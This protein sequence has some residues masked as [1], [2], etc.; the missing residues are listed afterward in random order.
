MIKELMR[1]NNTVNVMDKKDIS[2]DN[3]REM[4]KN[5]IEIFEH[6]SRRLIN[7]FFKKD[8]GD[9]YLD[10]MVTEEQ[11]LIKSD[12]RKRIRGRKASD[13]GRFPRDIDAILLEDIMY[14][15]TRDDL[16]RKYFKN[17][18]EPSYSGQAELRRIMKRLVDIRN[19]LSHGNHISIREAEQV[20]CYTN[21]FIDAYKLYYL[22]EG[23]EKDF[24]VP[25]FLSLSD[26]QGNN[27]YR[28]KI[29][30]VWEVWNVR[31]EDK[32]RM[33][34]YYS[35][36]IITRHRSGEE[37]CIELNVDNVF[38]PDSYKVEWYI[39]MHYK[40]I[41]TGNG[42]GINIKFT[43]DMVSSAPEIVAKLVTDKTWH[44]FGSSGCDDIVKIHLNTVLPPID[45]L[46]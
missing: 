26:S 28:K 18:F 45:D 30:G 21:D 38:S 40:K 4:S 9:D 29:E 5:Q 23:R 20:L 16:Y 14:F 10:A 6:W 1:A 15:F 39:E 43:N 8:Y 36:A 33:P 37:Y 12:I 2:F 35:D 24:N 44:R 31:K 27:V 41:M 13:P 3:I 7:D 34:E 46:Y 22:K 32:E 42:K 25:V 11:P 17:V 19:K